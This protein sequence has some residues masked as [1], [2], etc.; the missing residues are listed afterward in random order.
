MQY[1][2]LALFL[3]ILFATGGAARTD[4]QSLL[5]LHPISII[6]CAIAFMTL[7]LEDLKCRKSLLVF[8][9]AIFVSILL[10][11]IPLPPTI[12]Q[13]LA[14]REDLVIVGK[15]SDLSG[16]W[17]P[18]TVVPISGWDSLISL[19]TPLA[20]ILLGVQLTRND[21]LGLL[22]LM[23]GLATLS[24]LLGLLQVVGDPEGYLYFYKITNNGSAVGLFSNRNHAATLLAL[25]FPM[26]AIFVSAAEENAHLALL[27]RTIAPAIA[28]VAV[29]LILVTGSRSG[30]VSAVIGLVAAIILYRKPTDI[31]ARRDGN[32]RHGKVVAI[33]SGVGIIGVAS[34]TYFFS[35]AEAIERL[36]RNTPGGYDRPDFWAVAVD[37]FFKYLGWG[38]GS[39]SFSD[40][41][42]LLEPTRLLNSSYLNSA[43]NDWIETTV[44]FG[45]PGIIT[46]FAVLI[47]LTFRIHRL[48]LR[49]DGANRSVQYG[50]LASVMIVMLAIA[51]TSDYPLRTPIMMGIFALCVLWLVEAK[52][53]KSSGFPTLA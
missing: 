25:L 4:E 3:L 34:L 18:L 13:S 22:P 49:A 7:R 31:R 17:R 40:T 9:G 44:N 33:F 41:Y 30:L 6:G 23:V 20:V 26:L 2:V 46:I 19:F 51:S 28:I 50:R 10:H 12:W 5:I 37:L 15:L 35:R 45:I 48:W 42:R 27:R 36:F 43:H 53:N 1:W 29:P 32:P 16:T 39:G 21:L 8:T 52:Q 24:G 38:S 11:L 14:G 47:G